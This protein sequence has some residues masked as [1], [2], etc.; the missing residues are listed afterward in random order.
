MNYLAHIFLSG[1]KPQ[2][3][4]GNFVGD[5]VKGEQYKTLP[6]EMQ[7]GVLLHRKIDEFTDSH[8]DF[9][10][11]KSLLRPRFGRYSGIIVDMYFDYFLAKNFAE[12]SNGISLR[13]FTLRFYMSAI[14]NYSYLPQR[15][16]GFIFHFIGTNRL[17]SYASYNGLRESLQIMAD[18]KIPV[19][20]PE[21][22]VDFLRENEADIEHRFRHFMHDVKLFAAN[23]M[24]LSDCHESVAREV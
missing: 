17:S 8:P 10:V 20:N 7:M 18:Y 22:I 6:A 13:S 5:F 23:E 12:Y 15:V 16:K 3:Q 2:V 11:V 9:L 14:I 19:L 4:I 21:E 24:Q 1:G